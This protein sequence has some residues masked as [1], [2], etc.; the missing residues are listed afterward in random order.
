MAKSIKC[1]DSR[2]TIMT[3]ILTSDVLFILSGLGNKG[4]RSQSFY[5]FL[6]LG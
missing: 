5:R 6:A 3:E 2:H 1:Q 4:L